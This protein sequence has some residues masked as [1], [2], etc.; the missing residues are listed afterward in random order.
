MIL[1]ST[2]PRRIELVRRLGIPVTVVGP[3]AEECA[4]GSPTAV[5][6]E[7]ARR[8]A[9]SVPTNG[10]IVLG[11][12][13]VVGL[14]G[15]ILGKPIDDAA[16][17]DMLRRLRGRTHD[18][19]TGVCLTDGVH[20]VTTHAHTRV[21]VANLTEEE[22]CAYV[23]AGLSRGKAGAYGIQDEQL[24]GK[25]TADGDYDNVVGLPVGLVAVLLKEHFYGDNG[26]CR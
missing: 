9:C 18:V 26:N 6:E 2:S 10:E 11:A 17:V 5:A 24:R 8:K 14:D 7:N 22:I 21:T 23:S 19:V 12:D 16:A 13:T 15:V 25:V 1:A 3:T 20:T 4:C